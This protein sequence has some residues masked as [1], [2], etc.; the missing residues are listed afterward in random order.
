M[1]DE[2][3]AEFLPEFVRGSRARIRQALAMLSPTAAANSENEM[4]IDELM[5]T[6]A[7]EA[8]MIGLPEVATAART[9]QQAAK[10]CQGPQGR[11][12]LALIGCARAIRNLALLVDGLKPAS[13]GEPETNTGPNRRQGAP[14][15]G[16]VLLVDDSPINAAVLCGALEAAAV[17]AIAVRDDLEHAL[18]QVAE[19]RPHIVLIDAIMPNLDPKTLCQRIRAMPAGAGIKLLLFTAL[20]ADEAQQQAQQL[21]VDGLLS[22]DGGIEGIVNRVRSLLPGAQS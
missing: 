15:T 7:G 9:A 5:H 2:L 3:R 6:I 10:R 21:P 13:P 12:P 4:P 16:R 8:A 19:F 18:S 11:T 22:K 17:Q 1:L 14:E 20:A